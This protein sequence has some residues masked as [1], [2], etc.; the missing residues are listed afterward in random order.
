MERTEVI[1]TTYSSTWALRLPEIHDN[2][3]KARVF[4]AWLTGNGRMKTIDGGKHIEE[5]LK[6]A[7]NTTFKSIGLGG[8]VDIVPTDNITVSK[9]EW[10]FVVGSLVSYWVHRLKNSGKS[11]LANMVSDDIETAQDSATVETT[12]QAYLDGTG[13]GGLDFDGLQNIVADD[14]TTGTVGGINAATSTWWRN[15]FRD[16]AGINFTVDG[17]DYMSNMLNRCNDGSS[18]V[19]MIHTSQALW[20]LY[21]S[22]I[23]AQQMVVPGETKRS[24][25]A[26]L[27]FDV[28]WFRNIPISYD[29]NMP[30]ALNTS[31]YFLNSKSLRLIRHANAWF[32]LGEWY[33]VQGQSED[34]AAHILTAGNLVCNNR[35]RNGV[36]FNLS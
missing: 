13:N 27:G 7:K 1:D 29:T 12:R 28:L 15:Q 18:H 16:C 19:D 2:I 4:W 8:K 32:N 25:I 10:K 33:Q 14:P 20:E 24:K 35:R 21:E 34:R 6:Y 30:S 22:E 5:R 17:R 31:M 11:A 9:W 3:F 23:A 26:D 36:L